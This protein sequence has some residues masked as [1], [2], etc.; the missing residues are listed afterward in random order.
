MEVDLAWCIKC[1]CATATPD[2]LYCSVACL[3]KDR[4]PRPTTASPRPTPTSQACTTP[5]SSEINVAAVART[6]PPSPSAS[7]AAPE[8]TRNKAAAPQAGSWTARGSPPT[9]QAAFASFAGAAGSRL[10]RELFVG[11]S[12]STAAQTG[13]TGKYGAGGPS[14]EHSPHLPIGLRLLDGTTTPAAARV[15]PSPSHSAPSSPL[16]LPKPFAEDELEAAETASYRDVSE[17]HRALAFARP[18]RRVPGK[19]PSGP[20]ATRGRYP[21][22]LFVVAENDT[23]GPSAA[24]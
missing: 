17:C 19:R 24:A 16:P 14:P 21:A 2:A 8:N 3:T 22:V 13:R 5:P 23:P 4:P 7:E 18:R 1:G 20:S 6:P 11:A 9:V 15:V 12:F 10:P